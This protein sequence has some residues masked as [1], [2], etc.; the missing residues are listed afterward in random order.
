MKCPYCLSEVEA[1]ALV[2]KTCTKDLYLFKPMMEKVASL[3]ERLA[4]MPDRSALEG[5]IAELEAY[6]SE[7][8]QQ[9]ERQSESWARRAGQVL[10][11]L[12]IPL[13]VLLIGHAL[14]TVV[15]DLK[16]VYLR[17]LSIIV[18][19]PFAYVLFSRRERPIVPWFFGATALASCAVIGMSSIT[20]LVDGTPVLPQS[21]VE[22]KEFVEYS[23]SISFS[24]LTGMLLGGLAYTRQHRSGPSRISPWV[25]AVVAGLGDGK[26]TPQTLQKMMRTVNEFGG[27]AVALGTTA[28]SIY[29]GLKNVL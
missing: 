21:G 22:W 2:C 29:T 17:L 16:P 14:I 19:L 15:Y 11:F 1:E 24:F 10:Q 18:P 12:L 6:I 4:E 23:A 9:Q 5:R 8:R 28:M 7:M 25:A 27:M 26:L 3:E 20:A 13:M